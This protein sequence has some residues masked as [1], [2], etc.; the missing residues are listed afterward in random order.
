MLEILLVDIENVIVRTENN[1]NVTDPFDFALG[2]K[3]KPPVVKC[4]VFKDKIYIFIIVEYHTEKIFR[5]YKTS[6]EKIMK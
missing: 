2:D 1:G 4:L 5:K 3:A 6:R